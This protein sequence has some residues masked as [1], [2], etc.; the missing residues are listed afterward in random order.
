VN[1]RVGV[2]VAVGVCVSVGVKVGVLVDV[3]V[4]VLVW[5]LVEVG[6]NVGVGVGVGPARICVS[7]KRELFPRAESNWFPATAARFRAVP[8]ELAVT[9]MVT[10]DD[11]ERLPTGHVTVPQ[12]SVHA[13]PGPL[14]ETKVTWPGRTS[15]TTTPVAELGPPL[16]T[17]TV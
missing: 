3:G 10:D 15:V 5:V 7:M 16:D 6:V 12:F 2:K 1:V 14:P 8:A 11:P 13:P 17:F 4:D 9:V